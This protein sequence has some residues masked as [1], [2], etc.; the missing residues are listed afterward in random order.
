MG[1]ICR[2]GDI[3]KCWNDIGKLG[4]TRFMTTNIINKDNLIQGRYDV[5]C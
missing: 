2:C 1:M 4:M 5:S 3:E